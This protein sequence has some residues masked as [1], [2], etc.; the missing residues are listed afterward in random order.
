MALPLGR[1]WSQ[2]WRQWQVGRRIGCTGRLMVVALLAVLQQKTVQKKKVKE[3]ERER[4]SAS[5]T[6]LLRLLLLGFFSKSFLAL[7]AAAENGQCRPA[8]SLCVQCLRQNLPL[9]VKILLLRLLPHNHYGGEHYTTVSFAALPLY[10]LTSGVLGSVSVNSSSS[11]SRTVVQD[12][13]KESPPGASA[14]T[15]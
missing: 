2:W 8:S 7:A 5:H 14:G 4:E 6:W 15:R 12:L 13:R 9:P 3:R 1:R 11:F 10:L